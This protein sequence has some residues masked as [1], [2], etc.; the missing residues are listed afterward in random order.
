MNSSLC[1]LDV[2]VA[3]KEF[4]PIFAAIIVSYYIS[5]VCIGP[6]PPT[7]EI[8]TSHICREKQG[9]KDDKK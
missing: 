8:T 6:S 1:K 7:S 3:G 2:Q 9:N 4:F 5:A